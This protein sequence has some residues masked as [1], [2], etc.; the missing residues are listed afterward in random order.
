MLGIFMIRL[1][2]ATLIGL[3]CLALLIGNTGPK[4]FEMFKIKGWLPGGVTERVTITSK[5]FASAENSVDGREFYYVAWNGA[6]INLPSNQREN[7]TF[8]RWS[9]LKAG[10]TLEIV[11][12]P[13]TG[14]TYQRDGIFVSFGNFIFDLILVLIELS[15]IYLAYEVFTRRFRRRANASPA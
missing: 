1:I 15:G 5:S 7:L 13:W 6:D 10:D 4:I 12:I 14:K 11:A 9:G 2:A 8:E 3:T